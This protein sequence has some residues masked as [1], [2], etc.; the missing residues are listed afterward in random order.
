MLTLAA[1]FAFA[2]SG[3]GVKYDIT[4]KNAPEDGVS[5]YLLDRIT[6]EPIDSAVVTDGNFRMKG[7]AVKDAFLSVSFKDAKWYFPFF[8][9]GKPVFLNLADSTLTSSALNTKLSE[10]DKMDSAQFSDFNGFL[11]AYLSLPKEEQ[12]AQEAEFIREYEKRLEKY[13]DFYVDLVEKN[14]D[15]LI[16]VVFI[17]N[18][19]TLA[20]EEKFE[21]LMSSGALFTKHPYVQDLKR[22]LDEAGA[23]EKAQ[24]DQKNAFIGKKFLDLEEAAP[25]GKM[26]KLSE[27]AGQGK[28]VLVDFWASWCGP[29]K[30]E[31]PN[32]VAAYKKYHGKGFEIVGVSFDKEKEPWVK[33]ISEWEMPWIHLS[34]LKYWDN[35]A[36]DI[37]SVNAI[38]DNLLIDPEGTIV[39][40]GL[41]GSDLEAKLASVFE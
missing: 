21:E 4:G 34:D 30:A 33:A 28:W 24:A 11:R 37:Y 16:P 27:Y 32:V 19:H 20:G 22:K 31:M 40:R 14:L 12:E 2:C 3:N 1:A 38:P 35:A 29:C 26:H 39:A 10:L 36:H 7:K 5:V 25:D 13:G 8:N 17:S 18:V 41:R 6:S 15:N 9:D 23:E